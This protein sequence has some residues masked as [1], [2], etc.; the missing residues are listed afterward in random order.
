M[1]VLILHSELGVLRGGGENFTRNLFRA[2]ARRGHRVAAAFVAD[3]NGRYLIA[4]PSEINPIPICG[5]WSRNLGQTLLSSVA[6]R[7]P[8]NRRLKFV[9]NRCQGAM[10]W[11]VIR[12]HNERFQRRVK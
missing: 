12:W 10:S 8:L 11:R 7:L 2:F 1:N 4:L 9:W 3:R 5:W 6:Q